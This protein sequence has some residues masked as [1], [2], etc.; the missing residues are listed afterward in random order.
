MD[1]TTS[2]AYINKLGGKSPE[3]DSLA[4][5]IWFWC[6]ERK[7][8]IS[9]A[10]VPGKENCIADEESR[11][12]NDDT[13]WSLSTEMF[14]I[15]H[16]LYP[17]LKIDLFASRLNNKLSQYVSRRPDPNACAIDAFSITWDNKLF[18]IFPPFSLIPRILQKMEE[19]ETQAIL[20]APIWP[21][22]NWW[23][24][25]LR[26]IVGQCYRLPQARNILHLPHKPT[27]QY[28]LRKMNLGCFPI[29]GKP[30]NPKE[31]PD[32]LETLF[33]NHGENLPKNNTMCI[34]QN[35]SRSVAT[36][37]TPFNPQSM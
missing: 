1:N 30:L 23:P 6:I 34:S 4:R 24:S 14:K 10:H 31:S 12:E 2:C 35:G 7:I 27:V 13:E 29:S 16:D 19:D 11:T 15:I 26:L 37:L 3:L 5:E 17:G 33:S 9:A 36:K 18:F 8:H 20:I 22:Q 21:T 32:K 25:L 28:P